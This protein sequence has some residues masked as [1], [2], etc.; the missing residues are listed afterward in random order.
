[1]TT[2]T[3]LDSPLSGSWV[4]DSARAPQGHN[5]RRRAVVGDEFT[6]AVATLE[7]QQLCSDLVRDGAA[8]A[9]IDAC[10]HNAACRLLAAIEALCAQTATESPVALETVRD[11]FCDDNLRARR[12]LLDEGRLRRA[13]DALDAAAADA[14]P[15]AYES[16]LRRALR[17]LSAPLLPA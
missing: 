9:P 3:L 11:F 4:F 8:L 17:L 16:L 6:V 10:G 14:N 2:T 15:A 1:M 13:V 12:I 7:L 5:A